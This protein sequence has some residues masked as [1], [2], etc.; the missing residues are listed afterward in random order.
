LHVQKAGQGML[1][2]KTTV[3][4]IDCRKGT[5][6]S[7][8]TRLSPS[9]AI[10][11]WNILDGLGECELTPSIFLDTE[12]LPDMYPKIPNISNDI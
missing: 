10:S 7:L 4:S 11:Y 8:T 1:L 5:Y 12:R 9:T 6:E 2:E 3:T